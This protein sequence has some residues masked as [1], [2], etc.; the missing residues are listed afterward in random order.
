MRHIFPK[1]DVGGNAEL[2]QFCLAARR[3]LACDNFTSGKGLSKEDQKA[4]VA[5]LSEN[6]RSFKAAEPAG[7]KEALKQMYTA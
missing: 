3:L 4:I 7:I 1:F 6:E 5:P 2:S